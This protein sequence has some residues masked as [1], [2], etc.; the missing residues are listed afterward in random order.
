[1]GGC[2]AGEH[3]GVLTGPQDLP[4]FYRIAALIIHIS[5]RSEAGSGPRDGT[6]KMIRGHHS[7]TERIHEW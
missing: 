2:R 1:M 4:P 5:P 6:Y 3:P 7:D